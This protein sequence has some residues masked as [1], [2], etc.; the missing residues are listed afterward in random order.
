MNKIKEDKNRVLL[1]FENSSVCQFLKF[2]RRIQNWMIGS[3]DIF[4]GSEAVISHLHAG[5]SALTL[6]FVA[7]CCKY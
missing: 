7:H 6:S 1:G 2:F 4:L 3:S 5:N